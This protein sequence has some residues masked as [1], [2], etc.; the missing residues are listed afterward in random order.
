MAR[1]LC[2]LGRDVHLV[3]QE[4]NPDKFEFVSQAFAYDAEGIPR[5]LFARTTDFPGRCVVHVPDLAVL[6]VY[7]SPRKASTYVVPIPELGDEAIEEYVRRNAAV[8]EHVAE[9]FGVTGFCV[10]H[11]VLSSLAAQRAKETRGTPYAILPHGSAIEY[12]VKRDE[13]MLRAAASALR[14]ADFIFALNGEMEGRM[15]DVFGDVSG[16][17][18]R[19]R[20]LPVG[21]DTSQFETAELTERPRFVEELARMVADLP[22][23][24]TA[25]QKEDLRTRLRG[26]LAEPELIAQLR[27][28]TDYASA[29]PDADLEERLQSIDWK[30]A[31]V[32]VYVG[33]LTA[34]KGAATPVVSFPQVV[35]R[36]PHAR[37]VIAGTG[38]LRES[39]EA[40]VWALANGHGDLARRIINLGG[41]IETADAGA[42]PLFHAAGFFDR[43]EREGRWNDYVQTAADHMNEDHVLFTG[44]MDHG[45]L[46]RLYAVADAGVFP[47]VVREAS[48]L[49][50]PEAAAS[51]TVP[52]G[53]DFGGM[54]DSLKTLASHLPAEARDLL[55]VPHEADQA[56]D[57][58]IDRLNRVLD[59]PGRW[60]SDL[61]R[62]AIERYDWQSIAGDLASRLDEVGKA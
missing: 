30:E 52:I 20:R 28:G 2:L 22:R 26:D 40:L 10:N 6:P 46:S 38:A 27:I 17:E 21:V 35:A 47:S 55:V 49:V 14:D 23:G 57:E 36:H 9:E 56:V 12:V 33:R 34:A 18:E 7:V 16:I 41:G 31:G 48:P 11:V 62:A 53:T 24:R 60:S 50:V 42:D 58:L 25:R 51:G 15:R 13:R 45:P 54:G 5:E 3:C 29:A 43:L 32:I 61:R 19:M 4:S 1:A 39:L 37:L 44:F 8:L 59:S